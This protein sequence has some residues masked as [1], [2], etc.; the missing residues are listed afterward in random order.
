MSRSGSDRN[1]LLGILAVQMDF[2]TGDQLVAAMNQWVLNKRKSLSEHLVDAGV[3]TRETQTLLEALVDKHVEQHGGE[4]ERS[5]A[6]L[7]SVGPIKQELA[8]IADVDVQKSLTYAGAPA[9][10]DDRNSTIASTESLEVPSG[11]RFRILRPHAAGGLGKVSIARDQE[12]NREVAL[13]E[14]Q[15]RHA[16]NPNS[17]ARF[18][19]EAEITGGLEH[20]G[21]VPIYG[22]GQ[23]ADGRPF[24]AMRLIR[25]DNLAIA[26]EQFHKQASREWTSATD[27]LEL[28][29]LLGRMVDV[30]NAIEYAHSRG[31]LHRD[32]KPGNVM[33]GPYGETLVVDW[34]LAKPMQ[35]EGKTGADS[36]ATIDYF[37]ERTLAPQSG[38]GS[39]PTMMGS[40]VGT[41]A[42]MSPEQAGGRLNELGPASDVYSLGA[43]LYM[44]L[45]GK[46]PQNDD[47]L[48]IILQRVERGDFSRPRELNPAVPKGLEAIT[49]KAMAIK[50]SDRYASPRA[51][52]ND[53][54][55]WLADEPVS[56]LPES[57][58]LR[59][60]RWTGKHRTLVTSAAAV[61][62]VSALASLLGVL[63]LSVAN[64]REREAKDAALA[65]TAAARKAQAEAERQVERN[66]ALLAL[67]RKSLDRYETL[68]QAPQFNR[69]GMES[70][71]SDLQEAAIEYYNTLANQTG[72]SREAR[73]GRASALTRLGATYSQL[74]KMSEANDMMNQSLA[75][76][77]K[78]ESDFPDDIEY[79]RSVVQANL[80]RGEMAV[81]A[82]L[83]ADAAAPLTVAR[84]RLESLNK[85]PKALQQDSTWLAYTWSLEGERL[86]QLGQMEE[87]AATFG[88]GIEILRELDKKELDFEGR[89]DVSYRLSRALNQLATLESQVL[90]KFNEAR[91][92]FAEAEK[93]MRELWKQTPDRTDTG[94]GLVSI[95]RQSGFLASRENKIDEAKKLYRQ[96]IDVMA[97][98][99]A[100][101]P[102]V[103]SYRSE[104]AE[105]LHALGSVQHPLDPTP[106]SDE[107][108]GQI[109][110]AL[111][112]GRNLVELYPQ[113]TEW[114]EA[115]VRY[116][117]TLGAAYHKRQRDAESKKLFD[118]AVQQLDSIVGVS[119]SSV[120][121]LLSNGQLQATLAEQLEEIGDKKQAIE[122]LTAAAQTFEQLV[123]LAPRFGEGHLSLSNVY[124]DRSNLHEMQGYLVTALADL[125][126]V[127][128]K[129]NDI[130]SLSEAEWLQAGM[131]SVGVLAKT[132]RLGYL[133]RIRDGEIGLLADRGE[134]E[135]L[136]IEAQ[137]FPLQ[138]HEAADHYIAASILGR[139]A[140][141]AADDKKL[142]VEKRD[143]IVESLGAAAVKEL[144]AAWQAGYLV[145]AHGLGGLGGFF[146]STLTLD[147]LAENESL[148]PIRGRPD[149][150]KLVQRISTVKPN[151]NPKAEGPQEP[152]NQDAK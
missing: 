16:D 92:H 32:L 146:S 61:L 39:A 88:R 36:A 86:R 125:D 40:A 62:L 73:A 93:L 54:E 137:H 70:L 6:A 72:E 7:S 59:L 29:R 11:E 104:T 119:G 65:A 57:I 22:L 132:L 102:D 26:I 42:F 133:Y 126:R 136:R 150:V 142:A 17:R 106:P 63:T 140:Q 134:Y 58:A 115:V 66:D 120:D 23:Y 20:P 68:S 82:G 76:Y 90:W 5:L 1:L 79:Q 98:V 38:S 25:G 69:Y 124:M 97:Q 56:A 52:A 95:L 18:L 13:K 81:Y 113:K 47:D 122:V 151:P 46:P 60:K 109:E 89:H 33:L 87:A 123:K 100:K 48:G 135:A 30:C 108:I 28:R 141:T 118:D 145:Q 105:L 99:E 128:A 4:T 77:Q 103:P 74:G 51:M 27:V 41:P 15:D 147:D 143:A 80:N 152:A 138:T 24:Y 94:L 149:Y 21:V 31:V 101:A 2:A 84:N 71:R 116:E 14:L 50:P 139:A 148:K 49:L 131:K 85:N 114:K 75:L 121:T 127:I 110:Q 53:I 35:K 12:L 3:L 144:E 10:R 129:T 19:Q 64:Q 45:T 107:A 55:A 112:I 96:A 44:L 91:A 43:T 9:T 67:A 78:L 34:G 111:A 37:A 83:A 130:K 117:C 8:S